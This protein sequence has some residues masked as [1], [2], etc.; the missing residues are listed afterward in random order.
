M[1]FNQRK[2]RFDIYPRRSQKRL[3]GG[4][5][6][7]RVEPFQILFYGR[8]KLSHKRIAVAVHSAGPQTHK[9]VSLFYPAAVDDFVFLGDAHREPRHVVVVVGVK[10]RHFGCLS[11]DKS[12][13]RLPAPLAYSLDNHGHL[14]RHEP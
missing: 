7:L 10:A 12:A 8:E 14:L 6:K 9:S 11:A 5:S 2:Y 13:A 1:L 4:L 3:S